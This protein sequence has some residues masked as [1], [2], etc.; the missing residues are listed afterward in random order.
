VFPYGENVDIERSGLSGFEEESQHAGRD[1]YWPN[2]A[3]KQPAYN[4]PNWH[5]EL[6]CNIIEYGV[7][8]GLAEPIPD[9]G[10]K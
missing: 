4:R 7:V 5:Y 8:H 2:V 3:R 1:G 9:I 10:Q 6:G